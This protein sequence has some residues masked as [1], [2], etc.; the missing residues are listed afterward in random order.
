V[1]AFAGNPWR[2]GEDRCIILMGLLHECSIF[3]SDLK[4]AAFPINVVATRRSF[5]DVISG[6]PS[7]WAK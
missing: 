4:A 3:L 7:V 6:V 5:L 1:Q 2:E